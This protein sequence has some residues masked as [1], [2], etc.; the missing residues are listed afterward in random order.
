MNQI[1]RGKAL[2]DDIIDNSKAAALVEIKEMAVR[3]I[4]TRGASRA[5]LARDLG[6]GQPTLSRWVRDAIDGSPYGD[7]LACLHEEVGTLLK[8]KAALQ[9]ALRARKQ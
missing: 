2:R 1:R 7:V 5:Q 6:I 3:M 4:L 8:E 9:K